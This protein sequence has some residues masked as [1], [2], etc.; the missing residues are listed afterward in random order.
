MGSMS[1]RWHRVFNL[2]GNAVKI[3]AHFASSFTE[4][5][6]HSLLTTHIIPSFQLNMAI[7]NPLLSLSDT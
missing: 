6:I 7:D 4:G 1:L 2:M 3:P 5:A